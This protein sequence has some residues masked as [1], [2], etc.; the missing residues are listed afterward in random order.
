MQSIFENIVKSYSS[1]LAIYY[2]NEYM[3]YNELNIHVNRLAWFIK[4][5]L[6]TNS[7][8][9]SSLLAARSSVQTVAMDIRLNFGRRKDW[10]RGHG[11]SW[12]G[13]CI[14]S[15]LGGFAIDL[16]AKLVPQVTCCVSPESPAHP[17]GAVKHQRPKSQ[18]HR[19]H[20]QLAPTRT[21]THAWFVVADHPGPS[22]LAPESFR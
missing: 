9:L 5:K 4:S 20:L 22:P 6:G 10:P 17:S 7:C 11:I 1:N 8:I 19:G 16:W 14:H 12:D 21:E 2:E 3:T 18:T 13:G 15:K